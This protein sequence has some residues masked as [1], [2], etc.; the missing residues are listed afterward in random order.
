MCADA[1]GSRNC[2]NS[3]GNVAASSSNIPSQD[4]VIELYCF[5]KKLIM[6]GEISISLIFDR[7]IT[8]V[9]S[10]LSES[11]VSGFRYYCDDLLIVQLHTHTLKFLSF[12]SAFHVLCQMLERLELYSSTMIKDR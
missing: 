8:R 5:K 2:K 11:W 9:Y 6:I 10:S 3:Q 1:S 7:D 4:K 12:R